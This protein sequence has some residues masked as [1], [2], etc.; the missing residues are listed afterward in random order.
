MIINYAQNYHYWVLTFITNSFCNEY[1]NDIWYKY[2]VLGEAR[3]FLWCERREAEYCG[4]KHKMKNVLIF[5]LN[6][7]LHTLYKITKCLH[8]VVTCLFHFNV[9]IERMIWPNV[10]TTIYEKSPVIVLYCAHHTRD[11]LCNVLVT[12]SFHISLIMSPFFA[13][14]SLT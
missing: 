7:S 9:C 13:F 4:H 5:L 1:H 12:C 8:M 2:Q 14:L 6:I 10:K 11:W 3:A